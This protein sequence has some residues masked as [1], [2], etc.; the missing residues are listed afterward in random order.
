MKKTITSS[1]VIK[2]DF[3]SWFNWTEIWQNGVY[4]FLTLTLVLSFFEITNMVEWWKSPWREG[5]GL[6]G[7]LNTLHPSCSSKR[8]KHEI[9]ARSYLLVTCA[10]R[11]DS[12]HRKHRKQSV[13]QAQTLNARVVRS[14][15]SQ[16]AASFSH[17]YTSTHLKKDTTIED[18]STRGNHENIPK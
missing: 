9:Y 14:R 15:N 3:V 12:K 11:H 4:L 7:Y 13:L 5:C 1:K 18:I 8:K 17:H 2:F 6:L 16:S 10:L